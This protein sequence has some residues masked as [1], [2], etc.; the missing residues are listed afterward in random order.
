MIEVLPEFTPVTNPVALTVATVG[1]LEL[2][3]TCVELVRFVVRPVVPATPKRTSWLVWPDALSESPDGKSV[4][5]VTSSE[6]PAVTVRVATP[7]TTEP[8]VAF[9]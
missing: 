5:E 1:M 7:L 8:L 2:Q 3:V 6:A 9:V 4:S